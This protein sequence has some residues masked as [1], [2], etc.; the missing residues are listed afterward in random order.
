L[1]D[2]LIELGALKKEER[3]FLWVFNYNRFP[4]D[5]GRIEDRVRIRIRESLY[6]NRDMDTRDYI[7]LTLIGAAKLEAE[8]FPDEQV[9]EARERIS[10]LRADD[11]I[12][13]AITSAIKEFEAAMAIAITT[14]VIIPAVI[15]S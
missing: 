13:S 15:N 12:G 11:E 10:R 6:G 2:K 3:T 5:D 14:A 7:L 4:E 9:E 1:L 8:V